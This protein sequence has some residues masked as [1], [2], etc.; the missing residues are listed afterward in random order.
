[1]ARVLLVLPT[2]SYRAA[3]Y[4][5]AAESLGVELAI[6]SEEDPPLGMGDRFVRIDC[7][8]PE[9]AAEA[10]VDLATT[11][12]VDAIVPADDSGVVVAALAAER[13]GLP[14][15]PPHAAAATRNKA[16]MRRLLERGE[17]PQPTFRVVTSNDDPASV[18]EEVGYP[19]V[20]KP[21]SL[22][23]SRGVMRV[24]DPAEARAAVE[25]VRR[26]L[27]EAGANPNEPVLIEEY[28]PGAEV[29]VEAML[30]GGELEILAVFDKPDPLEG[31][32]FEETLYVT[33]SRLH[34]EVLDEVFDVTRRAVNAIGLREGP[35]HAELRIGNGIVRVVEVAARTIGGLC[36]RSLRFGLLGTPLEALVL[37]HGLGMRKPGLRREPTASGVMM[38]PIPGEGTLLGVEGVED[39]RA[40]PGVTEVDVTVPIGGRLRPLP[41]GDRYVGFVFARGGSPD[42]VEATL[43]HAASLIRFRVG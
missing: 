15:N 43:R 13:L 11:T 22:Q 28:M 35:I 38:L 42:D 31:P 6:A 1:M 3:D 37:R 39:A 24:D 4:V 8:R 27:V 34:P 18:A 32:Y 33:P 36:S 16:M 40:V 21:L 7:S 10:L 26:I 14:H 19:A 9:Q 5:A 29:A 23:G 12:P 25:R 41:E 20:V 30:W 17:V 2:G